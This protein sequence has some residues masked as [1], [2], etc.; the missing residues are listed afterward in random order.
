MKLFIED[1]YIYIWTQLRPMLE[2]EVD[3]RNKGMSTKP[4]PVMNWSGENKDE[5][6]G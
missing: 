5:D 6:V 2:W 3:D 4:D 1:L